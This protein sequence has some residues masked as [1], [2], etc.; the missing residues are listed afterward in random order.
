ME[1]MSDQ[2]ELELSAKGGHVGF[3]GGNI[4]FRPHYWLEKRI[5][6]FLEN[7]LE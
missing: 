6:K 3:V 2:V 4:P 7:H 1:E 5:P